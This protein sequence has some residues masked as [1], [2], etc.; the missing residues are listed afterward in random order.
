MDCRR[1]V[2][3][4]TVGLLEQTGHECCPNTYLLKESVLPKGSTP[5]LKFLSTTYRPNR[6]GGGKIMSSLHSDL[7]GI[8]HVPAE[9]VPLGQ[10]LKQAAGRATL[11]VQHRQMMLLSKLLTGIM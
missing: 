7:A 10:K 8:M 6:Y 11:S 9:R 3:S 2:I 4:W 1:P 5:Y